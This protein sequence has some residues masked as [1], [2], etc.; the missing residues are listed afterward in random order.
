MTRWADISAGDMVE[1]KGSA[2]LVVKAKHKPKRS[3]VTVRASAGEY[4]RD[5]DPR[6]KVTRLDQG[7]GPLRDDRGAQ[8]RWATADEAVADLGKGAR[9]DT[10]ATDAP[11]AAVESILGARLV[12]ES[13][14]VT[15]GYFVPPITLTTVRSHLALF[16]GLPGHE[17]PVDDADALAVH[18]ID[19]D[20]R[21][22]EAR[23]GAVDHWHTKRRPG[24]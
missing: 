15:A 3:R 9:W 16:H 11:G 23:A 7:D 4:T 10:P 19:H 21:D 1:L 18:R 14:G 12:A 24:S 13:P 20:T 5:V 22:H 8:R 2:W 17:Q 6:E